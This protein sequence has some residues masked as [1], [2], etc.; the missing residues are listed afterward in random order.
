M[1]DAIEQH[2]HLGKLH[3][4]KHLRHINP[5]SLS[6]RLEPIEAKRYMDSTIRDPH[7]EMHSS[8]EIR[9]QNITEPMA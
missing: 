7:E 9:E 4:G 1:E 2:P 3:T 5:A 6:E 8:C